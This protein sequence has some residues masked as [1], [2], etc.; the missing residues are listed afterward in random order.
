M[1]ARDS[2]LQ[3]IKENKPAASALPA[4][5]RYES[6]FEN[7]EAKFRETLAAIYTE[8]FV[9]K[10]QAELAQKAEELFVNVT[11]RATSIPA[12]ANWADFS[13]NV[14][15]PHELETIE[16]AIVQGEF[17]VAENGAVWVSDHYL[18]HRALPF[19]T[20]NLAFVIPRNSLMNN[21]HDAYERL[22]DTTGWGCFIAGPSK[23]ADI[24]QS[25]VIGAHGARS[26]VIFLIEEEFV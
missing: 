6:F 3:K 4:T 24:E 7:T 12:L 14:A 19:I 25:L 26:M 22:K 18:S 23:T 1:S 2:I 17:G 21:M 8:V 11:N 9:V 16:I 20:Q 15:D 10:D 5:L 13:L